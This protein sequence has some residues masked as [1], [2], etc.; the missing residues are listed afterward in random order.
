[1]KKHFHKDLLENAL[2]FPLCFIL[3]PLP[4]KAALCLGRGLG[5]LAG[6]LLAGKRKIATENMQRAFPDLSEKEIRQR[7]DAMFV[8]LGQSAMEM[9]RLDLLSDA[10]IRKIFVPTG[11]ENLRQ[12]YALNRGVILLSGHVGLWEVGTLLPKFGF[13]A[14]FVAKKM[15]NPQID[16]YFT[17]LREAGGGNCIVSK[18]GARA[19]VRSLAKNKAVGILMDQHRAPREAVSV[20]F[21]GRPAFTTPIIARLAMKHAI[22]VVPIFNYRVSDD[23]YDIQIHPMVFLKDEPETTVEENTALLTAIIEEAIRQDETQWFWVHRRW[24][25]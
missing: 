14:D 20:P 11:L 18:N 9:L 17:Q 21:F 6:R 3:R 2:F 24:R 13:P 19:I 4:R 10:E 16:R 8:H 5:R 23:R 25:N 22:P 1:M 12:A 15:R 7:V